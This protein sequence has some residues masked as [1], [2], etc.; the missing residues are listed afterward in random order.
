LT[1][2]GAF[3]KL[4]PSSKEI[5]RPEASQAGTVQNRSNEK[6]QF[7]E[8]GQ[9]IIRRSYGI[10]PYAFRMHASESAGGNFRQKRFLYRMR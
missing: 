10:N 9:N 6:E 1:S 4:S 3:P 2:E 8:K 5:F 7:C